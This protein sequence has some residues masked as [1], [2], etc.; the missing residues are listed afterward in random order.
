MPR[1]ELDGHI[2]SV[3]DDLVLNGPNATITCKQLLYDTT[4]ELSFED[5]I[6]YTAEM[7]AR[8]RIS[9]EGQEGMTSFLEKRKP[10]WVKK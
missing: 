1:E 9:E 2:K 8:L 6:E 10:N 5:S 3:T 4:N 7:I